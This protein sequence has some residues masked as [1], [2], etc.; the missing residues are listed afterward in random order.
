MLVSSWIRG[1][2]LWNG[3]ESLSTLEMKYMWDFFRFAILI[4]QISCSYWKWREFF[5]MYIVLNFSKRKFLF[6][7]YWACDMFFSLARLYIFVW[8]FLYMFADIYIFIYLFF[9]SW[10]FDA[11]S[12]ERTVHMNVVCLIEQFWSVWLCFGL[13]LDWRTIMYVKG[14]KYCPNSFRGFI[15]KR[16]NSMNLL[17]I[18]IKKLLNV[19]ESYTWWRCRKFFSLINFPFI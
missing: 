16:S 9:S 12:V 10:T 5:S 8:R 2:T 19:A 4:W 1:R 3:Y 6:I 15:E 18:N 17:N 11:F 14:G 13:L 7:V